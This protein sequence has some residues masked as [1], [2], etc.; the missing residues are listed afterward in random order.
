MSPTSTST[1][2]YTRTKTAVYLTDVVMGTIADI[3]A[4]LK[5]DITSLY[6]DW[7]QDESAIAAWI[8][9]E[10]LLQVVLECHQ[11]NGT[12]APII[13]FPVAYRSSGEGDATFTADR[14]SLA[15]Y[16]AKLVRVPAGTTYG[17]ICTFKVTPTPQPGWGPGHRASTEGLKSL[18][19]GT[20]ASAPHAALALRY[21]R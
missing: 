5:I 2:T 12:T 18:T 14:A 9:E 11:P 8:E 17:I 7:K 3:L 15:R 10:S 21:L 1:S 16:R 20:L 19:F 6:R 13:E 4:E